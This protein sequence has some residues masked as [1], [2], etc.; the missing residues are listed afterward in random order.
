MFSYFSLPSHHPPLPLIF[1]WLSPLFSLLLPL[2]FHW[3]LALLS[4][5]LSPP[6]GIYL[7]VYS[8]EADWWL[9]QYSCGRIPTPLWTAPHVT[10]ST[11]TILNH[12]NYPH[13]YNNQFDAYF[14]FNQS[15][16]AALLTP[17]NFPLGGGHDRSI[18]ATLYFT[19]HTPPSHPLLTCCFNLKSYLTILF[20][21]I[22]LSLS[23]VPP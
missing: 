8:F 9:Q 12:M 13:L 1:L 10:Y 11:V 7:I 16:S 20:S 4:L 18:D 3:I 5:P 17:R 19:S 23:I 14:I 21:S 6:P 2:H 22:F 15:I